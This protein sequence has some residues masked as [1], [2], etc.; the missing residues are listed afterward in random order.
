MPHTPNNADRDRPA[1]L[2]AS[3][4]LNKE[5][6]FPTTPCSVYIFTWKQ[7]VDAAAA[8]YNKTT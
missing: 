2:R 8:V 6:L 5:N 3:I 4:T 1:L 7:Q